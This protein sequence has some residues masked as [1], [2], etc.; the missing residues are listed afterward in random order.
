M[1]QV[2]AAYSAPN[3]TYEE[4]KRLAIQGEIA[5]PLTEFINTCRNEAFTLGV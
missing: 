1:Q 5:S 4:L 3:K 2:I